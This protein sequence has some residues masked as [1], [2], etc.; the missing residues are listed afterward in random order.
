MGTQSWWLP[1][2]ESKTKSILPFKSKWSANRTDT[3]WQIDNLFWYLPH[4]DWLIDLRS[5]STLC[6]I[7]ID[8]QSDLDQWQFPFSNKLWI[9]FIETTCIDHW[10][11]RLTVLTHSKVAI[12][13]SNYL[14][15]AP[16]NLWSYW[17]HL[18]SLFWTYDSKRDKKIY[19][20]SFDLDLKINFVFEN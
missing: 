19:I 7:L 3:V 1:W 17:Q 16:S 10:Q 20:F 9:G 14:L 18:N 4:F 15:A 8:I 11:I 6:A 12:D 5:D 2:F 13:R